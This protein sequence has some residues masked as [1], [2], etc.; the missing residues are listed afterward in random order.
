MKFP[1]FRFVRPQTETLQISLPP[2][3]P[4]GLRRGSAVRMRDLDPVTAEWFAGVAV[5]L[6]EKPDMFSKTRV[7][8]NFFTLGDG[9]WYVYTRGYYFKD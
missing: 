4:G 6:K 8:F 1:N 5:G 9:L 3:S 7:I 2:T